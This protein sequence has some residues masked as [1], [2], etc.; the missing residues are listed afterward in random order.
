MKMSKAL[1]FY[2]PAHTGI[3]KN[4]ILEIFLVATECEMLALFVIYL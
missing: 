1:K 4:L 2:Y 3:K